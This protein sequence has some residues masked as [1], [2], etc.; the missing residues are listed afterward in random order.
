MVSTRQREYP[1]GRARAAAAQFVTA[2]RDLAA[3]ASDGNADERVP[4][5]GQWAHPVLD[6]HPPIARG[7]AG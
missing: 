2:E 7:P 5:V 3:Q 1:G 6:L 4:R